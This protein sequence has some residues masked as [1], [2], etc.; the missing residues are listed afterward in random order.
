MSSYQNLKVYQVAKE[1]DEK[2]FELTNTFP[3]YELYSLTDQIRRSTHSIVSNIAEGFGRKFYKQEY[4]R[5]LTFSRG[6]CN[7]SREHLKASLTRGY[8]SKANFDILDDKLDHL[9]RMLT[10]LIKKI[11]FTEKIF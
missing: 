7:E 9:G 6:S 5:F 3:K 2:I 11:K 8:C 1:V 4:I 10:M